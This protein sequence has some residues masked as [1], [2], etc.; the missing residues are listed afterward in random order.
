MQITMLRC[1]VQECDDDRMVRFH[2]GLHREILDIVD[3]KDYNTTNQLLHLAL[4]AE[5]EL[6]GHQ[7]AARNT[8][9]TSSTPR[10]T[11]GQAKTAPFSSRTRTPTPSSSPRV[12]EVS[13]ST[14]LQAPAQS[15]SSATSTGRAKPIVCHRCHGMGHVMKDCPSQQAYIVTDDGGYVS[16]SDVEDEVALVTNLAAPDYDDATAKM[17]DEVLGTA[18]TA[19]YRT[20]IVQRVLSAQI[21]QEERLQ[22]HNL[23]QM[24]LIVHNYRVRVIIDGGSYNNLVSSDLVKKLGLTT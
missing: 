4:L 16:A 19:N 11:L 21:K 17:G 3:Y 12:P 5:K 22:H 9:G 18:A 20:I 6:Q 2:S 14:V 24:F 1:D 13:K 15:S 7:Q 23:F 10:S 8:F